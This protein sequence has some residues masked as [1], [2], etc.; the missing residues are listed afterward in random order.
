MGAVAVIGISL[1]VGCGSAAHPVSQTTGVP[2]SPAALSVAR[3]F[4]QTAVGRKNLAVAYNHIVGR[5]LKAGVS[6]VEWLKGNNP[7]PYFPASNLETAPLKVTSSTKKALWLE[8]VLKGGPEVRVHKPVAF[9][10]EVDRIR[11]RWLVNYFLAI[12]HTRLPAIESE[13]RSTTG[14]SAGSADR[15]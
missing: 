5:F 2:A 14:A 13:V 3:T 9:R 8:I 11:G 10:M 7:V 6:R 15:S 1:C 12:P 4:L